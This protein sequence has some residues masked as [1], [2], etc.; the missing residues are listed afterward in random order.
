MEGET[1]AITG[2]PA[3]SWTLENVTLENVRRREESGKGN[4]SAVAEVFSGVVCILEDQRSFFK[5]CEE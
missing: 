4:R 5:L 1:A 3:P 2:V